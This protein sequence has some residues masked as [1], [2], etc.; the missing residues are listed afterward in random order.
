MVANLENLLPRK[1]LLVNWKNCLNTSENFLHIY[2]IFWNYPEGCTSILTEI[3]RGG[4]I[5]VFF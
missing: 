1:K 2:D 3:M 5:K 4:S